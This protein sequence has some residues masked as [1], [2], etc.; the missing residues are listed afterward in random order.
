MKIKSTN[1][2]IKISKYII[3]KSN[4]GND[5]HYI[6]VM[7]KEIGVSAATVSRYAK[8]K[9]FYNFSAMR[10][11]FNE[12]NKIK[13][14]DDLGLV[15]FLLKSKEV[16]I[17]PSIKTKPHCELLSHRLKEVGINCWI[18][19]FNNY[20]EDLANIKKATSIICLNFIEESLRT[21]EAMKIKKNKIMIIDYIDKQSKKKNIKKITLQRVEEEY[22]HLL[23][24][25]SIS[26]EM[27]LWLDEVLNIFTLSK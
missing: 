8:R 19:D 3:K 20:K 6:K 24:Q 17:V 9:G 10:A 4:K 22:N 21:R 2:E 1:N 15:D 16:A 7:A 25:S 5:L 14:F 23:E 13:V 18:V 26:R 11:K 12:S 27:Y